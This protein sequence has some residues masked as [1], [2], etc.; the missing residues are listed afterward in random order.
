MLIMSSITD[1]GVK[2]KPGGVA[3]VL[4]EGSFQLC[5]SFPLI[6]WIASF[7]INSLGQKKQLRIL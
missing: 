4:L 7:Q 5:V 6:Q 2:L 3:L 1:I